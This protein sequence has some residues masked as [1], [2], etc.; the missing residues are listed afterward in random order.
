MSHR[1][2]HWLAG[3]AI[4]ALL[5]LGAVSSAQAQPRPHG[6]MALSEIDPAQLPEFKGRIAQFTL[7]PFGEIVGL[8]LA[9]GT[10][11]QTPPF[12]STQLAYSLKPGDAVTIRGLKARAVAMVDAV[13]ITNDASGVVITLP[14]MLPPQER[15]RSDFAGKVRVV[16]HTPRG[17]AD[18]AILEDGTELRLPPPEAAKFT[19]LLKPGA[20]VA[21]RGVITSSALGKVIGVTDLGAQAGQLV[22]LQMPRFGAEMWRGHGGPHPGQDPHFG[23][24][25]MAP[26]PPPKP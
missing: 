23:P 5:T 25:D 11:V 7:A 15:P 3:T 12:L 6:G 1:N 2:P 4:A 8:I 9:D 14:A 24:H 26:V 20:V 22:H 16:L 10:E 18:G 13:S 21:G 19:E 17:E